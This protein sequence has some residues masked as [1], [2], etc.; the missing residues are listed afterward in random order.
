MLN[1]NLP[2]T[3]YLWSTAAS[4]PTIN[5]NVDNL[6]LAADDTQID[7]ILINSGTAPVNK[8]LCDL[9]RILEDG[10]PGTPQTVTV[11]EVNP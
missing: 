8:D 9:P 2:N 7:D 3:R 4:G 10:C 6:F 5:G 11:T 1:S